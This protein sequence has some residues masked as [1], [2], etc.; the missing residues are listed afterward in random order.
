[1]TFIK[2]NQATIPFY[3]HLRE[4]SYDME[5][6][7][8]RINSHC[9]AILDDALPSKEKDL[10]SFTLPC[11]IN[12]LCVNKALIDL[13]ASVSV[14]AYS[15]F[16]NLDLRKL[17]PTNLIIELADRT[18]KRPKGIAKNMLIEIDKFVL[19]AD[20]IVL[21]MP[22]DIKTP[23]I[24]GRP[25]LSTT[26]AIIDV[27]KRKFALR[28]GNHKIVFKNNNPTNRSQNLKFGDFLK[29]NDLNEPLE[30][31][32]Q[33]MEDL[34]CTIKE[35]EVINERMEDIVETRHNDKDIID[36]I[37]EYPCFCEYD[38]KIHIN[39]AYNL[40]FSC[41]ISC[42]NMDAYRDKDMGDVIAGKPFCR[43]VCVKARRFYGLITICNGNDSVTYQMAR[44]HPRLPTSVLNGKSPYK[45]VFSKKPSLS[46]LKSFGCL[47]FA[48]ILSS[49]YKFSSRLEKC[50]LAGYSGFKKGYKLAL[51]HVNFFNEV[52]VVD[53]G[54]P[55]DDI[56]I[57]IENKIH[58]M[59]MEEMALLIGVSPPIC[60]FLICFVATIPLSFFHRYVPGGSM[61]KHIYAAFTGAALS[62]M[63]FGLMSNMHFLVLIIVSYASM[64]SCRK[65]CGLITFFLAMGYL[66]GCHVY[67][68]SGDL[69][70]EG[71][72]DAT[73]S[74][75]KN[76]RLIKLPSFIE[77]VGYCLC[78]GSHFAGPVYEMK[79]YLDWTE[80][81]GIW[82]KSEKPSPSPYVPTVKVLFQ[83][84]CSMILSGLGFS[85][86][87]NSS[88]PIA[89]WGRAKNVDIL[90]VEFAKSAAEIPL[91][92]NIHVST[93]LRHYVYDRL[94]QKGKRPG[95]FQLL[96]T[97]TV[98]AIWHGVY[99]GYIIFFV[100]SALMISGSKTVYRWQQA[101]PSTNRGLK[102]MIMLLN[103][104]YTVLVLNYSAVGFIVLSLN[105]TINAYRS[106]YFIGT[107]VPVVFIILVLCVAMAVTNVSAA[108]S[109]TSRS[110]VPAWI[111][112]IRLLIINHK[113]F[114]IRR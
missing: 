22:K 47:C 44:S 103:F 84:E 109:I 3:V 38:R 55:Y 64:V 68:M 40:Q 39:Y 88:P 11:Y 27:Y 85:G 54:V 26:H 12:N 20:F 66:I 113:D 51:N 2:F 33:E 104:A 65:Q 41:M 76:N 96:A 7:K 106:V 9:L 56:V 19:P 63:S 32:N 59:N 75:M 107:V 14:M 53:L 23:L 34:G 77:Y 108:S 78:C 45:L 30:L 91:T 62:Y 31:R 73:G 37:D 4:Y 57:N 25:F 72:I 87:T 8:A 111:V 13:E 67:Y 61:G 105:E 89:R 94:V 42:E 52:D 98:S 43:E 93:W 99:P 90:G 97:Q 35:G 82:V 70:K 5:E 100:Q 28:V 15:T 95:F 102:K 69:W 114:L 21:D 24:L 86:W 1:M 74:M 83:A 81:K 101:V 60:Q 16:T 49:K 80:R 58:K 48:T 10:R 110:G 79:D 46:H 18:V 92:W 17:A 112:L 29:L 50:V 6:I 71:G 36:E